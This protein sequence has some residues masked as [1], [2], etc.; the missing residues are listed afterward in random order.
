M[1]DQPPTL[2]EPVNLDGYA[3][4]PGWHA[5]LVAELLERSLHHHARNG[6]TPNPQ[7]VKALHA[8]RAAAARWTNQPRTFDSENAKAAAAEDAAPSDAMTNTTCTTSEAA[9]DLGVTEQRVGQLL[10]AGHLD[11]EQHTRGAPWS[12]S[13]DSVDRLKTE[14]NSCG[15]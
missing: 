4:L 1:P 7:A 12:V 6:A 5:H 15:R 13:R 14:R 11:G 9:A 8:C 10:A 3:V 2:I